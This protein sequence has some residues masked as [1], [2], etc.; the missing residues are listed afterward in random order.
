M[1]VTVLELADEYLQSFYA[2]N[3]DIHHLYKTTYQQI[4]TNLG[5]EYESF[6]L[7][8]KTH[9]DDLTRLEAHLQLHVPN[10]YPNHIYMTY[11]CF[12]ERFEQI[13][14]LFD[15]YHAK[16]IATKSN[17]E[18]ITKSKK[19]L[20]LLC[21][22]VNILTPKYQ[23]IYNL[24]EISTL[25]SLQYPLFI[26]LL[27]GGNSKGIIYSNLCYVH[28]QLEQEIKRMLSLDPIGSDGSGSG[29]GGVI[30]E[31][32]IP[33]TEY[34]ALILGNG[35]LPHPQV[36]TVAED[37]VATI[38]D[39]IQVFEPVKI[40][41]FNLPFKTNFGKFISEHEYCHQEVNDDDMKTRIVGI[42]KKIHIAY[43]SNGHARIDLRAN[44]T[45]G[46]LYLLDYNN[47]PDWF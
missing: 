25:S 29:S 34:T 18:I 43:G 47:F 20:K 14:K 23:I 39:S 44:D 41:F 32:F 28:T 11:C 31:E 21:E 17:Y 22:Q 2:E 13:F 37:R 38:E 12:Y 7:T 35:S 42:A 8:G 46:E 27:N 45:T 36:D 16:Y 24:S 9:E 19:Q 26:K 30:V 3:Y 40:K 5:W 6:Q 33:G 4:I 10:G 15:R 1:K